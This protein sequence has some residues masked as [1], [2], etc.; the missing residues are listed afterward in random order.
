[1]VRFSA[2]ILAVML[3]AGCA[4]SGSD[5]AGTTNSGSEFFVAA[6]S[7]TLNDVLSEYNQAVND[8]S[9]YEQV[10]DC[11]DTQ[12][13]KQQSRC[14]T[15]LLEPLSAA[16]PDVSAALG[17]VSARESLNAQC[18]AAIG[19]G[20]ED[21]DVFATEVDTLI[22]DLSK[23]GNDAVYDA[24]IDRYFTVLDGGAT[25]L[26]EALRTITTPCYS[27]D[28]LASASAAASPGPSAS[29]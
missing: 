13:I 18:Q 3:L 23:T 26:N 22:T 12:R 16:I 21:V 9:S 17:A 27:P 25:S 29:P 2:A 28:D 24:A 6:D 4:S 7:D 5:A 1:M 11:S 8:A 10:V 14:L 19:A 20:I 15:G